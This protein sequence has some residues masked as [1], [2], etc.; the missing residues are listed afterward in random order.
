VGSAGAILVTTDG[1]ATWSAQ[2]SGTT[3][4]LYGVAFSDATR[5]WAVGGGYPLAGVI[6]ATTNGGFPPAPTAPPKIV[7]LKPPSA[8]RGATVTISGSGF[9]ASQ[10]T[11]TVKFGSKSCATYVSWSAAQITCQVPAKAK[12]GTVK[13][14]VTTTAGKSNGKSFKVKR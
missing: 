3:A 2:A 4:P 8:K 1:G 14:T 12:Y 13:V 7:K 9:G 5:G 10:G 6:L 11:S